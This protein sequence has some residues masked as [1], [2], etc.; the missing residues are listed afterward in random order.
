[1]K[2]KK[3]SLTIAAATLTL[4]SGCAAFK[5]NNL[6]V[7]NDADLYP[8]AN[9]KTKV[10]TR[11]SIDTDADLNDTQKAMH[12]AASKERF[13][14]I[15]K[16][17]DCCTIVEGPT[18]AD[19]VV[20]G[21]TYVEDHSDAMVGAF[22]T[23]L[24]LYTIPSWLT[25]TPQITAEVTS[26]ETKHTYSFQDSMTM[27]QWLP[28]IFALPFTGDPISEGQKM[29]NNVYKNLLLN[30]QKDGLLK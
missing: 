15:I 7:V 19:V 25:V 2:S 24:S 18:E 23:G 16:G 12:A 14:E 20:T 29:E 4:L 9:S 13:E 5:E 22:I 11:W 17:S 10:F 1:M 21:R 26:G 30:I 6:P 27:V 3:V 28:M 8:A